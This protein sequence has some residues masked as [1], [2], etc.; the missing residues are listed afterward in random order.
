MEYHITKGDPVNGAEV[1]TLALA[2]QNSN[3]EHA[4]S[5]ALL[6]VY[7]DGAVEDAESYTGTIILERDVTIQFSGWAARYVLPVYPVKSFTSL[8]YYDKDGVEQTVDASDYRFYENVGEHR[9]QMLFDTYPDLEED[10]PFPVE[11]VVRA[12]YATAAMPAKIKS[13]VMMR[14]SQREMYREDQPIPTSQDRAFNALL[15]PLKRY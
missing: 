7:L 11:I 3:I 12:G 10:N 1:V 8:K 14:F 9:L 15:R 2:K 6:Q 13:A 4:D 5:D